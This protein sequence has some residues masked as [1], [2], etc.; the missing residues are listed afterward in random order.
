VR[1]KHSIARL[2]HV[3]PRQ[4]RLMRTDQR[5]HRAPAGFRLSLALFVA[6]GSRRIEP[7]VNG[8][9][10]AHGFGGGTHPRPAGRPSQLRTFPRSRDLHRRRP[11]LPTGSPQFAG[12]PHRSSHTRPRWVRRENRVVAAQKSVLCLAPFLLTRRRHRPARGKT[13]G[14]PHSRYRS[15]RCGPRSRPW[16][17]SDRRRPI[18][19]I[20]STP[21]GSVEGAQ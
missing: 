17:P 11:N 6:N 13:P 7:T 15:G 9:Q 12:W 14:Q 18:S 5:A 19:P 10:P 16:L 4:L 2:T 3:A 8:P 20:R 21:N 1:S